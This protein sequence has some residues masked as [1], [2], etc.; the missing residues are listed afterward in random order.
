MD[1]EMKSIITEKEI[2]ALNQNAVTIIE[3]KYIVFDDEK[4]MIGYPNAYGYQNSSQDRA[5]LEEN[6][7]SNIVNCIIAMWGDKPTIE[8]EVV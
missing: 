4:Q 3:K 6:E 5:S 1:V 7:E 2:Q 8:S